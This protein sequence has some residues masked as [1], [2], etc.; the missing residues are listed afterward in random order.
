[1]GIHRR[2]EHS[3][4]MRKTEKLLGLELIRFVSAL[5]VLFWHYQQFT[6][7]AD[8]PVDF[9]RDHQP[10][11][12]VF[13]FLYD[14]GALGVP[15]FWAISG[16]IFFWKYA[17]AIAAG[18]VGKWQFFVLRFSRLYPLHVVTL[19]LVAA[20]Q[21]TYFQS[22]GVYFVYQDNTVPQFLL[23]LFM[24]TSWAPGTNVASFNGPIWS[25]S[26]EVLVYVLFFMCVRLVG[27]RFV[28]PLTIFAL[29]IGLKLLQI[30]FQV[31]DCAAFFYL[32]LLCAQ[33]C[34]TGFV[35]QHRMLFGWL[36][37]GLLGLAWL[38]LT[39]GPS[40]ASPHFPV[41]VTAILLPAALYLCAEILHPPRIFERYIAFAGNLTYSSYLVHFP[42]V[43]GMVLLMDAS[44]RRVHYESASLFVA[45]IGIT[46]GLAALVYR[47]FEV[48]AQH[49]LRSGLTTARHRPSIST[50]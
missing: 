36:S 13:S 16:F 10:F 44:G 8:R 38:G 14:H 19:L 34:R 43:L 27:P 47:Y 26:A 49:Y 29:A 46:M 18:L 41:A 4:T 7:T 2:R 30:R 21:H 22:A 50:G 11:Y 40:V 1:M 35:Q 6:Y 12:G 42:V 24:A 20:L 37:A 9:I 15:V 32:G 3:H 33:W 31:L 23:Q 28:V 25:V 45:Y 39:F 17:D 48:P 5:G